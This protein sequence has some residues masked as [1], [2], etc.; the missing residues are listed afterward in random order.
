MLKMAR[1]AEDRLYNTDI[2]HVKLRSVQTGLVTTEALVSRADMEDT[3]QHPLPAKIILTRKVR[4]PSLHP[5]AN[6]GQC[7]RFA[8]FFF[9][10]FF[11]LMLT[12]VD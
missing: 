9:F 8:F 3:I 2:G 12:P 6:V 10:F 11:F 7:T 1:P 4:Q 5:C